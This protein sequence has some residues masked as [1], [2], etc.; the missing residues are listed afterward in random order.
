VV[1]GQTVIEGIHAEGPIIQTLGGMAQS[2]TDPSSSEFSAL[3]HLL[4]P[5]LKVMTI[6]PSLESKNNYLRYT[7]LLKENVVP[8]LGHDTLATEEDILGALRIAH[9]HK[10][11]VHMTHMFNVSKFHHREVGLVNIGILS[12]F[13]NLEKYQNIVE[14]SVEMIGDLVHVHPLALKLALVSKDNKKIAFISDAIME[15]GCEG[16]SV[17]YSGR[18]I[19]NSKNQVVLENTTTLA[20]SCTNFLE[21]F[22]NLTDILKVPVP[23]AI[24]M[25]TQNP[26]TIAGLDHI[27]I[28]EKGKR[29]DVLLFS[30]NLQLEKVFINGNIAWK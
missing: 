7:A 15:A 5:A 28:L 14:P 20:G 8:A 11:S 19:V 25:L 26:A 24:T 10:K 12:Q 3:L 27:G 22:R 6:S 21:T 23:I 1:Q 30:Q 13:P 9:E 18:K 2:N 16:L 29:A 4:L 17:I